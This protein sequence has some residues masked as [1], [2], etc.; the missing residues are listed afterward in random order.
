MAAHAQREDRHAES[1]GRVGSRFSE[2]EKVVKT[3]PEIVRVAGE[4]SDHHLARESVIP[5]W[6][7]SM[8]GENVGGGD[9][10]EGSVILQPR[11]LHVLADSFQGEERGVA[12]V[13]MIDLRMD[14]KGVQG[15]D[16]A[17]A[18]DNLLP[19]SHLQIAAI[20]LFGDRAIF[21]R[22]LLDIRIK[23]VKF[24][25]ADLELPDFGSHISAKHRD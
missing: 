22:I 25:P 10:L 12:F 3:D 11:V 2:S 13:H 16:S 17:Y 23:Q 14:A 21:R 7:R 19:N 20:K 18:E 5:C 15:P 1:I 6:H 24:D 9:H 8:S 4:I